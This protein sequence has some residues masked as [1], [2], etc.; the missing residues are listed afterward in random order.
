VNQL[1]DLVFTVGFY[2]LVATFLNTF[3]VTT[4]GEP[5]P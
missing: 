5:A 4:D 1:G 2:Q 3:D